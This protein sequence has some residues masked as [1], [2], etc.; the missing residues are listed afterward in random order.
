MRFHSACLTGVTHVL[1]LLVIFYALGTLLS[2]Q[3]AGVGILVGIAL[4]R[5]LKKVFKAMH[6]MSSKDAQNVA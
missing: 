2:S 6:K 5:M 3:L 1:D 4:Q